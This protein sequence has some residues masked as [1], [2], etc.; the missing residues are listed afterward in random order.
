MFLGILEKM[1]MCH[2]YLLFFLLAFTG[3][4]LIAYE[5]IRHIKKYRDCKIE[6]IED[7]AIVVII[8]IITMSMLTSVILAAYLKELL[9][10]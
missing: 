9:V 10:G 5:F 6:N 3:I 4:V 8:T 2:P 1:K 7:L